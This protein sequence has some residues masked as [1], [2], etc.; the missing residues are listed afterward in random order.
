MSM[1]DGTVPRA[2]AQVGDRAIVALG[3]TFPAGETPL[4]VRIWRRTTRGVAALARCPPRSAVCPPRVAWSSRPPRPTRGHRPGAP[5]S[6]GSTSSPAP[7]RSSG[8]TLDIPDRYENVRPSVRS[9][10]SVR[11]SWWPRPRWTRRRCRSVR[12]RRSIGSDWPLESVDGHRARRGG[13]VAGHGARLRPGARQDRVAVAYL[14]RA[15]GLGVR[16]PD[17]S[18]DPVGRR[19]TRLSPGPFA[20]RH[21]RA[22][23]AAIIDRRD[24]DPWVVFAAR[25]GEAWAP[26]IY[27]IELTWS[28]TGRP[29]TRRTWHIELRPGPTLGSAATPGA[30]AGLGEAC[31]AR[32]GSWSA[33]PNRSKAARAAPPS[34]CSS[35]RARHATQALDGRVRRDGRGRQPRGLRPGLSGR[36]PTRGRPRRRGC[37]RRHDQGRP[38]T[39]TPATPCPGSP[40]WPRPMGATFLPGIYRS[41]DRGTWRGSAGHHGLRRRRDDAVTPDRG[42]D[43]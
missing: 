29:C 8:S 23:A 21:R 24:D 30:D 33:A 1:G 15:T 43:T 14:P 6:T 35:D 22:S 32:P 5:G 11:P 18:R 26:G 39:V 25:R 37:A 36:R 2:V 13:C 16:L 31:R 28:A 10:P 34:A 41:D 19:S 9:T 40:W 38:D 20:G 42:A 3:I 7:A 12:S 27:R 17:G 4:D